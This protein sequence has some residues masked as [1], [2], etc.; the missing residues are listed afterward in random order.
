[1]LGARPAR[2]LLFKDHIAFE[3]FFAVGVGVVEFFAELRG[4]WCWV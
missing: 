2:R 4:N 3:S 1:M